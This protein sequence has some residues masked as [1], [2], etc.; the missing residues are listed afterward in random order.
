MTLCTLCGQ[1]FGGVRAFDAHR[2]GSHDHCFDLSHPDGRRCLSVEEM[3][4]RGLQ[5]NSAGRWSLPWSLTLSAETKARRNGTEAAETESGS[6]Q[7]A[8]QP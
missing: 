4:G 6:A 5:R 2:V 3:A 1:D 8:D 7:E